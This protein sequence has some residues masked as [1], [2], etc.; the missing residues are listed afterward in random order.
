MTKCTQE[1][2]CCQ[3]W[4]PQL[5]WSILF[6]TGFHVPKP[7]SI[8]AHNLGYDFIALKRKEDKV[9]T[10]VWDVAESSWT[11]SH[12]K[13][14]AGL[15]RGLAAASDMD[16]DTF[17]VVMVGTKRQKDLLLPPQTKW[18]LSVLISMPGPALLHSIGES[19][20]G[21]GTRPTAG[22]HCICHL[23]VVLNSNIQ[24]T[25]LK[26]APPQ[27][28]IFPS[29][30]SSCDGSPAVFLFVP[31]VQYLGQSFLISLWMICMRGSSAPSVSL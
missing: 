29:L 23:S 21:A 1:T 9:N 20:R 31:W 19:D 3:V 26:H 18:M 10:E 16:R 11:C 8:K 4:F 6:D 13:S 30:F 7:P 17:P 12:C 24:D 14:F 2:N 22:S 25:S 27:F 5:L 15:F 28:P